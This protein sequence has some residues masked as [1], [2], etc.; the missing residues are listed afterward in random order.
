LLRIA[1]SNVS[2]DRS[3]IYHPVAIAWILLATAGVLAMAHVV[4]GCLFSIGWR[5]SVNEK[6]TP[7]N[8]S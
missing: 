4:F 6:Q 1:S 3:A 7:I 8:N 5:L 2:P